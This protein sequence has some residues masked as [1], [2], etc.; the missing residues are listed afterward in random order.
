MKTPHKFLALSFRKKSF[1][2]VRSPIAMALA[3]GALGALPAR[4]ATYTFTNGGGDNQYTTAANWSGGVVPNTAAGD[5]AVINNGSAVQYTPGG[6]LVL[7]GGTLEVSNGSFTQ[8]GGNN[9]IQLGQNGTAGTVLVDGGTFNQGTDSASPFNLGPGTGNLFKITSGAVNLDAT[10]VLNPGL[11]F[12]QSGGTL[13]VTAGETQ[14]NSTT[15]TLSG[16]MLSTTLITGVNV[17]N[18]RF[19]ISGGTL[20]LT[21]ANFNGIY[22]GGTSQ[23]INFTPGS[24]GKITFSSGSTTTTDAQNFIN[25]GV[26]EYNSG[27]TGTLSNFNITSSGGVVT[28]SLV[29]AVVPE[30]SSVA[31]MA[32]GAVG[33]VGWTMRRRSASV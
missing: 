6:D 14:F 28:V 22:A 31:L 17:A 19:D 33:L 2:R 4:A 27:G 20:N 26:I 32:L 5:N 11:T 7:N 10:F 8:V 1:D 16:G 3:I 18:D 9:Y 12:A 13:N 15:N 21:G 23:F 24:N 25:N 30:P 29:G